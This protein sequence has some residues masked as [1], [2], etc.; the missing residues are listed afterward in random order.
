MHFSAFAL[1][2]FL[3]FFWHMHICNASEDSYVCHIQ[4][5][6]NAFQHI[7]F[8]KHCSCRFNYRTIVSLGHTILL[9]CTYIHE[10][11][12][13][14]PSFCRYPVNWPEKY[15]F[16]SSDRRHLNFLLVSYSIKLFRFKK[17]ENASLFFSIRKIHV[18]LEKASIK[19]T[20][21]Q[22][23]LKLRLCIGLQSSERIKSS[24][25]LLRLR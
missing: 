21:Y 25:L 16:L 20:K 22:H 4:L 7:L 11:S 8:V 12:L 15:S 17:H 3:F 24:L 13:W 2:F 6:P 9:W 10:N 14:I 19:E 1:S 23:P 5:V 18:C